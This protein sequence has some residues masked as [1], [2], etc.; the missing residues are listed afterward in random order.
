MTALIFNLILM[1]LNGLQA[2][3]YGIRY[4]KSKKENGRHKKVFGWITLTF[5]ILFASD[6]A[7]V[8][9]GLLTDFA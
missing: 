5:I 8:L 7:L 3:L 6:L 4:L 1:I 2:L 9:Y